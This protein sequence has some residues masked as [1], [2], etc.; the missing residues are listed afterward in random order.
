MIFHFLFFIFVHMNGMNGLK[1]LVDSFG[2]LKDPIFE[3]IE[4]KKCILLQRDLNEHNLN[5]VDRISE[6]LNEKADIICISTI[7]NIRGKEELLEICRRGGLVLAGIEENSALSALG[8]FQKWMKKNSNQHVHKILAENFIGI[9]G[10]EIKEQE[11][12][13]T[14]ISGEE[15]VKSA[16]REGETLA[17]SSHVKILK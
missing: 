15:Q 13:V 2:E 14:S 5:L 1:P 4:N 6:S 8:T 10:E 3:K 16:L 9:V 7:E 17:L 11:F 12:R